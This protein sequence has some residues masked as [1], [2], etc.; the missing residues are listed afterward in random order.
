MA[1]IGKIRSY[2]GL[3]I[4][5]IGVALVAFVLGDFMGYGP[6][7]AQDM[8]V[9]V[10]GKSK[11]MYPEFENRVAQQSENWRQQTGN[12]TI[13][14]RENFQIRQQV[15]NQMLREILLSNE[16]E[17]LGLE[18]SPDELTDLI[19]GNDPHPAIIQSFSNPADGTYDPEVVLNFLQNLDMMEPQMQNQW[20]QLEEYIKQQRQETKYHNLIKKGHYIPDALASADFRDRNAS[21]DIRLIAKRYIDI[22]DSLVV[23]N[24]RAL[25]NTYNENKHKF[26]QEEARDLEYVVFPIFPSEQDRENARAEVERFKSEME[27]TENVESLINSVSDR[28]FDPS[29]YGPGQLSP[30]IDSLMFNASI[31]TTYGPY[32]EN[33]SYVV[34]MLKDIQFRPDSMKASHILIAHQAS[35]G[36]NQD[37]RL[38]RQQASDKADSLLAVVRSNPNR[39]GQL[40]AT[41]SDDPSAVANQGDL[42]WFNDGDMVKPFN[43]AVINTSVNNFVVAESDFGFHVI[44]VTGKSSPS[45]KVQVA[46]I[47]REIDYSNQTYQ[48]IY[49]QASE[50][51][52]LL[53]DGVDFDDAIEQ[54]GL[55]KRIMDD[56]RQ[57]DNNIPGIENPRSIIQWAFADRTRQGS[58]S[59]IFDLEGNF[60]IAHLAEVKEEGTPSLEQI[61]QEIMNI[62]IQEQKASL[63]AQQ[64]NEA[65]GNTL[66]EKAANLGLEINNIENISFTNNNIQ[67]FGPEPA[68]VGS[69]FALEENAL[70]Q[71]VTGNSG[72]FLLEVIQMNEPI[73]P[74]NLTTQQRQLQT[75][76]KNRVEAE[77]FRAIQESADIKDRRHRFY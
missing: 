75:T 2:S 21:A 23:V 38:N 71:P 14:P 72:V 15:W 22:D 35:Q 42:G 52:A 18:V 64:F 58:I 13:G 19:I 62:A 32:I 29:Y 39:F 47:T 59:Q 31:G 37:T 68:V 33:N 20:F 30:E 44:Q 66:S 53:R 46:K 5:V 67:G 9:G 65:P 43:D 28:R 11:I 54:M 7:G 4:A 27:E 6:S 63:L 40:A 17:T 73:I 56:V 48:R 24:D 51:A 25:R 36:A 77:A 50:F 16:F 69:T 55:S 74:D 60:V 12:Q 10:I 8:E 1:V 41:L 61:R 34:A 70:S 76:F 57:M 26:K 49:G 45:R 3:L